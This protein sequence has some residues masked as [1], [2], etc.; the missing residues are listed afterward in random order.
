M[1]HFT[2]AAMLTTLFELAYLHQG[3]VPDDGTTSAKGTSHACGARGNSPAAPNGATDT[4]DLGHHCDLPRDVLPSSSKCLVFHEGEQKSWKDIFFRRGDT[5]VSPGN[6]HASYW[7]I[8]PAK[9]MVG[10]ESQSH[11]K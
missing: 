6:A 8:R 2:D 11:E 9:E 4:G 7:R 1:C 10:Q 5:S 3:G